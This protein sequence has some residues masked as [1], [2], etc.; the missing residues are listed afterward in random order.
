MLWHK[1]PETK[2]IFAQN[3]KKCVILIPLVMNMKVHLPRNLALDM[4]DMFL[5]YSL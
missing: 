2:L 3:I 4:F 5:K 1:R